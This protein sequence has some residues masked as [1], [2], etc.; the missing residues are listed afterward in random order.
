MR[1][2]SIGRWHI[3]TISEGGVIGH[4]DMIG[5]VGHVVREMDKMMGDGELQNLLLTDQSV[6]PSLRTMSHDLSEGAVWRG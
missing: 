3:T 1:R 6:A 2:G 4:V 5:H